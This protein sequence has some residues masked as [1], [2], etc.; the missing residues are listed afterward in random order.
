MV[1]KPLPGIGLTPTSYVVLLL[2]S[3]A[4]F[5]FWGGPLWTAG[6]QASHL[7]RIGFSYLAVVPL[8]ALLLL[9]RKQLTWTHLL[10]ACGSIWA[11]K[12]VLTVTLYDVIAPDRRPGLEPRSA[13]EARRT[14][15]ARYQPS[16][17]TFQSG[18]IIGSV[19]GPAG[20]IKEASVFLESPPPGSPLAAPRKVEIA[21]QSS[22]Y[23]QPLYVTSRSDMLVAVN[24]DATLHTLRVRAGGRPFSS[25]PIPGSPQPRP[26]HLPP[27]GVYEVNCANHAS[28]I[29]WLVVVD[30]PYVARSDQAGRFV[31]NNVPLGEVR[32]QV[33]GVAPTPDGGFAL[34]RGS[35]VARVGQG[36]QDLAISVTNAPSNPLTSL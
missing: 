15:V 32:V 22:R 33:A 14:T 28:E 26:I 7:A 20:A 25:Q 8:A 23:S 3:I 1:R 13:S 9:W 29:A 24:H 4:L 11:I 31:L 12:L 19:V 21:I 17:T 18:E 6:R 2:T 34:L 27:P 35:A 5:L 36:T 30:H 10:G 16:S